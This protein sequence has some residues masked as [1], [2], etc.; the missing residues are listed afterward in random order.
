MLYDIFEIKFSD[1]ISTAYTDINCWLKKIAKVQISVISYSGFCCYGG[2]V[3]AFTAEVLFEI[4]FTDAIS[5]FMM[6]LI[7]SPFLRGINTTKTMKPWLN[8]E[9]EIRCSVAR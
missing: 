5:E 4:A 9:V 7:F 6:V 8:R 2:G 1:S 3:L